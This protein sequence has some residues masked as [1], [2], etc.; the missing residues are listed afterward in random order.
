MSVYEKGLVTI[1]GLDLVLAA[2]A[3]P[4][5]LRRVPR[6]VVYG[7]RTRTTLADDGVWYAA[8]AHFG[9]GLLL[10]CLASAVGILILRASRASPFA[11]LPASV[12]VLLIPLLVAT[13]ATSRF[14]RRLTRNGSMTRP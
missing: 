5:M 2:I 12:A 4:L 1:L 6:N 10:A 9:R 11:F 13:A 8:N 3:I 7:Y 14:V